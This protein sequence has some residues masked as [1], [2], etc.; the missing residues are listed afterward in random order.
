MVW[1]K[2]ATATALAMLLASPAAAAQ[3]WLIDH[4]ARATTFADRE[5]V[6]E[7]GQRRTIWVR[8]ELPPG[9]RISATSTHWRYDCAARTSEMLT[10][11]GFDPSRRALPREVP[12]EDQRRPEAVRPGTI[13]DNALRFA[14]GTNE[15]RAVLPFAF[16]VARPPEEVAALI[17]RLE[18]MA[19]PPLR[20]RF[21]A[22][23]TF[24]RAAAAG[25]GPQYLA[26][27][28]ETFR[29]DQRSAAAA[30]LGIEDW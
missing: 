13:H 14:C 16:A 18:A 26:L 24:E 25:V 17:P 19:V 2:T 12:P 5:S 20:A 1:L 4:N 8:I 28:R 6:D 30:L 15:E 23:F 29:E 10:T 3:W 11:I 27:F 9:G 21:L 7:A 22:S